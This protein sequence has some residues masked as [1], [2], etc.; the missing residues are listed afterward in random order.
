[1]A[2]GK[3]N[4]YTKPGLIGLVFIEPK[5][6][7]V[8]TK[9]A[10]TKQ[11][12]ELVRGLTKSTYGYRGIHRCACGQHSD[13][14]DHFFTPPRRQKP[15]HITTA[16]L[17]H[18]VEFHRAEIPAEDIAELEKVLKLES[19]EMVLAQPANARNHTVV[20]ADDCNVASQVPLRRGTY[21]QCVEYLRQNWN[22]LKKSRMSANWE[23]NILNPDGQF[24]SF[25]IK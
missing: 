22:N 5:L 3:S 8:A 18:Y 6:A 12:R 24:C 13:N 19:G 7:P 9:D 17:L 23:L 14:R 2:I 10:L 4:S 11:T 16:L 20:W 25:V 15:T 1:M 21:D